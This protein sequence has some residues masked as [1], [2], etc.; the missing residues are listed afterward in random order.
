MSPIGPMVKDPADI[1]SLGTIHV[2]G[3]LCKRLEVEV[4]RGLGK[5]PRVVSYPRMRIGMQTMPGSFET[6]QFH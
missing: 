6:A 5:S 4:Y 2:L 1:G 3:Q